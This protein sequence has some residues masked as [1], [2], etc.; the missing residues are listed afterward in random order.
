MEAAIPLL[1]TVD[2]AAGQLQI[3]RARLYQLL[4]QGAIRSVHI[5]RLRRIP[6]EALQEYINGLAA[7]AAASD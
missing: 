6:A 7:S 1:L 2:Q 5:G 3:S 4:S